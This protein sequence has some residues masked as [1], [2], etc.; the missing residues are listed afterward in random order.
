MSHLYMACVRLQLFF[1]YLKWLLIKFW[2]HF[3]PILLI[4]GQPMQ[5][6]LVKGS[7]S[8]FAAGPGLAKLSIRE[9]HP[10][11]LPAPL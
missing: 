9:L 3:S 2:L 8:Q 10:G 11:Q 5:G 6:G 7:V 1:E 4:F